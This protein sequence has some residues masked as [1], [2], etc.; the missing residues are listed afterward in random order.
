MA[1][2]RANIDRAIVMTQYDLRGFAHPLGFRVDHM[3]SAKAL[4]ATTGNLVA[5]ACGIRDEDGGA[6][7]YLSY[8]D[9]CY[10]AYLEMCKALAEACDLSQKE[11]IQ[12]LVQEIVRQHDQMVAEV[13]VGT[14]EE[15]PYLK[16]LE[17]G[18]RWGKAVLALVE[19][20]EVDLEMAAAA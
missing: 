18:N 6:R 4:D 10:S 13:K 2:K 8:F 11:A 3:A 7:E 5:F 20:F 19:A 16:P 1:F 12:L 9:S 14:R 17:K 15:S